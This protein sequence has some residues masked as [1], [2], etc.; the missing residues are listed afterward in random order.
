MDARTRSDLQFPRILEAAADLC[1]TMRGRER[2]LQA[3][4]LAGGLPEID[5]ELWL[6]EEA[7]WLLDH[8][9]RPSLDG[10]EDM[11]PRFQAAAK[12]AVLSAQELIACARMIEA[13]ARARRALMA[14][15]LRAPSLAALVQPLPDL[16][17]VAEFVL[18]AFDEEGRIRD[19]ASPRLAELRARALTLQRRVKAL[20]E[21]MTRDER[22][23]PMLQDDYYTI[24]EG[25]YVL[26]VKAEDHRF[27]V[28]ILH[29]A[30]QTGQTLFIE[31]QSIVEENNHLKM[32]LEGIAAEEHAVLA[33][34]SRL[35]GRQAEAA[36]RIADALWR[37]DAILG[38]ARLARAMG[39]RRP[40]IGGEVL[41][42]VEARNP[43]LLL[44]GR[45][46]VPTSLEMPGGGSGGALILSGPNAGGK[47]V[48][49][50]TV[51]LCVLMVQHGLLP[52]VRE[53]TVLPEYARVFTV[54]GDP[55]S[56]DRALST[57]TGQVS[58][59]M[60]ALEGARGRVLVLLDELGTG[61][62]PRRGEALAI[63]IIEALVERGAE[64]LVATHFDGLK[65]RGAEDPRFRNGRMG[66]DPKTGLPDYSLSLGEA[67]ESNPFEIARQVGL[68]EDILA[69][70]R[71]LVGDQE[72]QLEEALAA[73]R[74]L[75]A[76]LEQEKRETEDLKR[77]LAE[78]K[79]RYEKEL[80]RIRNDSDR[81]VHEAR[82]E[83]L[84][85]MKRL[86]EELEAIARQARA[87]KA[88]MA[89]PTAVE[90]VKARRQQVTERKREVRREMD[91]EEETRAPSEPLP[92]ESFRE[93]TLAYVVPLRAVGRVVEV[94]PD[95][96]RGVVQVGLLRTPVKRT[97]L[98]VPDPGASSGPPVGGPSRKDPPRPPEPSRPPPPPPESRE[99]GFIR[100]ETNTLD[101][102]GMRADEALAALEAF[103]DQAWLRED[104]EVLVIHGIGTS[105]LRKAI[106]EYLKK[107]RYCRSFRPGETREGGEGVTFVLLAL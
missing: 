93:G 54:I 39:G 33:D 61:T 31:P 60:E 94:A 70:A 28:G 48:A 21:E 104:P 32:V 7:L 18:G 41:R 63:A 10:V 62:E 8:P 95:G 88:R 72:R 42:V 49:L 56:M 80:H 30:S 84:Q 24:R 71:A 43:L 78:D 27:V 40:T 96:K 29:G 75:K 46:V 55:T 4:P 1:Q 6:V 51:G 44:L 59:V 81:L 90:T 23:R 68:S 5:R 86:E 85:K 79:R 22:I 50:S 73:A 47:S 101:V 100:T 106:R 16:G 67:G 15:D 76:A 99:G 65:R 89:E 36:A 2:V 82:R 74:A 3:T 103:L 17:T 45:T 98:R 52:P 11:V 77:R 20:V 83:V 91:R 64:C 34:R 35:I 25:R 37:L 53:G 38:R 66:L 9:D 105:A 58:R 92:A 97:D 69:R 19:D 14:L 102:R 87:E 26:P 13:G 12:G 107:S 57:F